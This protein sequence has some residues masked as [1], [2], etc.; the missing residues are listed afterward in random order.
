MAESLTKHFVGTRP[1]TYTFT[2]SIAEALVAS[3]SRELPVAIVRPS[4]IGSTWKGP[5]AG[6]VDNFN[7]ATCRS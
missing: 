4:I 6:W 5:I 2:K 7:G 1:N 3:Y